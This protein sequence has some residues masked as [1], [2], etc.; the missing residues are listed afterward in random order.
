M[1]PGVAV[2]AEKSV[3]VSVEEA[4]RL[5]GVS[6]SYG[7]ELARA[8]TLPGVLRI[9]KRFRVSKSTLLRYINGWQPPEETVTELDRLV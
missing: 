2:E 6:R 4:A 5:C 8:G 7:Y 9:G 3:T 1:G